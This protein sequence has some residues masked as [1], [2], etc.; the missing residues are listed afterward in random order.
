MFYQDNARSHTSTATRK[1]LRELSWEVFMLY[2][3]DLASSDVAFEKFAGREAYENGHSQYFVNRD[4][5]FYE[6]GNMKLPSKWQ[7]LSN[8]TVYI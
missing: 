8:K 6:S 5:H 1:N 3:P 2:R 4:A 7:Q